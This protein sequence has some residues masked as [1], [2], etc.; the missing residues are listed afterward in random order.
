MERP[1]SLHSHRLNHNSS[2]LPSWRIS[3]LAAKSLLASTSSNE[4]DDDASKPLHHHHHHHHRPSRTATAISILPTSPDVKREH[5]RNRSES[6]ANSPFRPSLPPR[7]VTSS[8]A[9]AG[10]SAGLAIQFDNA[11]QLPSIA[12]Q[13]ARNAPALPASHSG[14]GYLGKGPPPA[15]LTQRVSLQAIETENSTK[16]W[17]VN[18]FAIAADSKDDAKPLPA[19]PQ[20]SQSITPL[21]P[22]IRAFKTTR[23][24]SWEVN[25]T[26]PRRTSMDQDDTVPPLDGYDAQ[27]LS[28]REREEQSSED[29]DLFLK[30]AREETAGAS[31]G[32]IRR[33]RRRA[34]SLCSNANA[35]RAFSCLWLEINCSF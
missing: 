28:R 12:K 35:R 23:R 16:D 3:D 25:V 14:N 31:R 6:V 21:I 17:V 27:R 26:S 30:L 10:A 11:S 4:E 2:K 22:P 29:S 1:I 7:P 24:S 19:E 9:G 33:V 20:E 15:M 32:P 18:Q 8:G 5:I 13:K 34:F